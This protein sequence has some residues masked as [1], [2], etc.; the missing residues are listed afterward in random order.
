M[1]VIDEKAGIRLEWVRRF[2]R[3]MILKIARFI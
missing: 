2:Y 3:I 1:K